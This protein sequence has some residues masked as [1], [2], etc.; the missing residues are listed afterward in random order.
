VLRLCDRER[1]RLLPTTVHF[2][3]SGQRAPLIVFAHGFWGHPRK[4]GRLFAHW[5]AAGY[6]VA[7]PAFPHTSDENPPPF[8][9]EDVVNQPADISF[10]LDEVLA[11]DIGDRDRVGIGGYSLGAE[12]SL[13]VALHPDYAD[14]RFRAV[15]AIAGGFFHPA[16]A[17]D[18][19]QPV[20]LLFIQGTEDE[21]VKPAE[22]LRVFDMASVPKQ[23]VWLEGAAHDICQ[24]SAGSHVDRVAACAADFYREYLRESG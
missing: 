5:T 7:A 22:A 12:T 17:T 9:I 11:R 2:P 6:V 23:L 18:T 8:R 1:G 14:P 10:V 20:P 24:D 4:F 13:A 16:F 19:L 21:S 3:A 15:V